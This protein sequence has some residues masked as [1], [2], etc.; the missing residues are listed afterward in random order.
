[1]CYDA[2]PPQ[3]GT[4]GLWTNTASRRDHG[5]RGGHGGRRSRPAR[6]RGGRQQGGD[7]VIAVEEA[8][9]ELQKWGAFAFGLVLGWFLYFLNRYRKEVSLA[10][11]TTVIGAVGGGAVLALFPAKTDLFGAYGVGLA[12]GFFGYLLVLV[13]LVVKSEN[14]GVDYLVD[15]R[16]T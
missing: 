15:G 5:Q 6:G 2:S 16:R 10:D 7:T 4:R 12:V 8:A 3:S 13:G 9:T 1:M 14:F 11:L